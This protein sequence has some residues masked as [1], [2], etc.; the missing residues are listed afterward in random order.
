MA[1]QKNSELAKVY[2]SA[3]FNNTLVNVTNEKGQS[4]LYE[5]LPPSSIN[6]K[7]HHWTFRNVTNNFGELLACKYALQIAQKLGV[8]KI[9]GDSN[10][11]I[12]SWSKGFVKAENKSLG[13]LNLVA[14]VAKLRA[15]FENEGGKISHIP[16]ASNPADLGF[17]K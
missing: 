1:T 5:I 17:H 12:E 15:E 4:L 11:V 2:V 8:R 9:F 16:G 3:S 7:G 6:K 14:E 10:L 13:T